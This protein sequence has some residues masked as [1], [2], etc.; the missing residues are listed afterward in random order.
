MAATVPMPRSASS[1]RRG[2]VRHKVHVPAYATF[3][4]A[5]Q[6]EM[7]DLYEVLD[8]SETGVGVQCSVPMQVD[9]TVELRLD[10]AEGG[11]EICGMARVAWSD[12]AG[13]VGLAIPSLT[14]SDTRRMR[15]WLFLNS[16][17]AAANSE[18]SAAL[19]LDSDNSAL[20]QNYTDMLSAAS[21]VQRETESLGA[22][23]EAIL[24]LVA[25]RSRSLFRASGAAIAL[26]GKNAD[27]M[28]C[29]ASAGP[30]APPVGVSLR[31]G[32]GFSGECVRAGRLL[33]CDD[34]ESDERVDLQSCRTLGIRSILAVPVRGGEKVIGLLEVFSAEPG[35][36]NEDGSTVLQRF[37]EM[38]Q[39][40]VNRAMRAHDLSETPPASPKPFSPPGSVLFAQ[41]PEEAKDDKSASGNQDTV[42]GI[43]LPRLHLFLLIAAAA[44]V[45]LALGFI[46][47]PWIQ[48][49]L[50]AR[51]Q[52]GEHTVLAS[53]KAPADALSLPSLSADSANLAQLRELAERGDP[54]AENALG[55]LY[56]QGDEKQAVKP[57][58]SEAARWFTKAAEHGSVPAQSK[59]GS[60]YFS[61]RGLPKDNNQAYFWTVLARANGDAGSKALAPFIAV[62]LPVAQRAVI[63][64]QADQWLQRHESSAKPLPGR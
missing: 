58:E 7:L 28:V 9:A 14:D 39:A 20:R 11:E 10:L 60:L 29:R 34:T 32:S 53:S 25:S 30:S 46:L 22:D 63:E 16:L 31:V 37:A 2:R 48:E 6:N 45:A 4:R 57:D 8:I 54:A 41:L 5:S 35:A 40:A 61:G 36:F 17:A 49:K 59:L 13:H 42:G 51:E 44:T 47:A 55:L 15:R 1:N 3:G 50:Q 38:I 33:R 64:Q 27:S 43:R 62:R 23:L 21:A 56:A 52:N 24:A 18:S 12:S 19:P 26:V